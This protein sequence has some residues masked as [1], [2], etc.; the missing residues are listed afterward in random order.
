M[1][2]LLAVRL[3]ALLVKDFWVLSSLGFGLNHLVISCRFLKVILPYEVRST[4]IF[5]LVSICGFLAHS[6]SKALLS[7]Q[8]QLVCHLDAICQCVSIITLV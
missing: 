8:F 3:K 6:P 5:Y 7:L 2:G 1:V 4:K